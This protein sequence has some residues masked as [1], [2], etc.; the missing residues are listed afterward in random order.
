MRTSKPDVHLPFR[1]DVSFFHGDRAAFSPRGNGTVVVFEMHKAFAKCS[2][3][4]RVVGV[5]VNRLAQM[6]RRIVELPRGHQGLREGKAQERGISTVFEHLQEFLDHRH[7]I[8]MVG[9]M[10]IDTTSSAV[11]VKRRL[12]LPRSKPPLKERSVSP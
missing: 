5:L 7:S 2:P 1:L 12:A 8:A 3:G 9:F 4:C 6:L 10:Q 11:E